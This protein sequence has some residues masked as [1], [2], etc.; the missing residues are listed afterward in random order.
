M[1]DDFHTPL[2][3]ARFVLD[4]CSVINLN[5]LDTGFLELQQHYQRKRVMLAKTDVVDTERAPPGRSSEF[6]KFI[7]EIDLLELHGVAVFGHSRIGHS[8]FGSRDDETLLQEIAALVSAGRRSN[9]NK[10]NDLRDAMHI[11]T[12]IR[13]K[14][15]GFITGDK[16]LLR[17]DRTIQTKFG[18]RVVNVSTAL[19]LIEEHLRR[20]NPRKPPSY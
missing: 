8:V 15:D 4:T 9:R 19:Q 3:V 7:S 20:Q 10:V 12:A 18:L 16:R 2:T 5:S 1:R 13:Y 11:S 6:H 17:L 14:W